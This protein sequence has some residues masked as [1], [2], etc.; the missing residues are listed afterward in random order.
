M[1]DKRK[2]KTPQD[3][4]EIHRKQP[5]ARTAKAKNGGGSQAENERWAII[6]VNS[7]KSY[8]FLFYILV[9]RGLIIF[10]VRFKITIA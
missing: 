10:K 1:A 4:K 9:F 6:L 8:N 7:S 3:T 2:K 5:K